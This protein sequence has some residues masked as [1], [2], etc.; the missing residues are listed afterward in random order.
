MKRFKWRKGNQFWN[1]EAESFSSPVVSLRT[2]G[3]RLGV[4]WF[5][6][7]FPPLIW[8]VCWPRH[9]AEEK[10]EPSLLCGEMHP[11]HRLGGLLPQTHSVFSVSPVCRCLSSLNCSLIRVFIAFLQLT[12]LHDVKLRPAR[13][14]LYTY[15]L[16]LLYSAELKPFNQVIIY[17]DYNLW[18]HH[19]N[20]RAGTS[21]SVRQCETDKDWHDWLQ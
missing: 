1:C 5:I 7:L 21:F 12:S 8:T 17:K 11:R 13:L 9:W 15:Y 16:S 19:S 6:F 10:F 4:P 14:L 20:S 2:S 18:E 3:V